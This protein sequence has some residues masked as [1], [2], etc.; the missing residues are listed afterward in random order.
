[1]NNEL[2]LD[3]QPS[4]DLTSRVKAL[5][6]GKRRYLRL[7]SRARQY[8]VESRTDTLTKLWNRRAL[9][10]KIQQW[11]QRFKP[12]IVS[13][14]DVDYFKA[15]NDSKGYTGGD[16]VL[17]NLAQLILAGV[18]K[19]DFVCRYGGDEFLVV[20]PGTTEKQA[21]SRLEKVRERFESAEKAVS[22]SLGVTAWNETDSFDE[23]LARAEALMRESK[24][25]KKATDKVASRLAS[26][27]NS[28]EQNREQVC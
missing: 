13:L 7:E 6:T 20:L 3:G 24:A 2:K 23:A 9:L 5:S 1:M 22:F 4:S 19:S 26:D 18:R 16:M 8:F 27:F 12:R 11:S 21:R 14:I 25:G 10:D 28:R 17:A 15:V